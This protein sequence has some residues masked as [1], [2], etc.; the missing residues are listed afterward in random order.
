MRRLLIPVLALAAAA[1]AAAQQQSLGV[2]GLWG[3]FAE[4]NR[5]FAISEPLQPRR[6][7]RSRAFASVGWFPAQGVKGQLHI[8]FAEPKR[9]GSAVLLRIDERTFQLVGGG[10]NA[11]APDPRADAEIVAAM[12]SGL[13]MRVETRNSRGGLMRESFALRG[14]ATALDAAA[15][16]CAPKR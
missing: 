1:P 4:K 15:I 12:R 8:R 2:F 10:Q 13:E 5:C 3:A 7:G 16:A 9:Q 6:N 14:A 11:W